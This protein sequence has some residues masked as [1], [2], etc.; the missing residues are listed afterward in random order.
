M[1]DLGLA[2]TKRCAN[3]RVTTPHGSAGSFAGRTTRRLPLLETR[4]FAVALIRCNPR[5]RRMALACTA[6]AQ[7]V[8]SPAP[9]ATYSR[10]T[11]DPSRV[12]RHRRSAP[13]LRKTTGA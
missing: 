2:R 9:T 3:T 5:S 8:R 10:Q 6:P 7:P 13:Y 11:L 12:D 4:P 1:A